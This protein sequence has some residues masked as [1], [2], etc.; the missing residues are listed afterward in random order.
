MAPASSHALVRL[1][2]T[3]TLVDEARHFEAPLTVRST[4]LPSRE[5]CRWSQP[6]PLASVPLKDALVEE[7]GLHPQNMRLMIWKYEKF[8]S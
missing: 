1:S 2:I 8:L 3:S 4:P 6:V 5:T 7:R